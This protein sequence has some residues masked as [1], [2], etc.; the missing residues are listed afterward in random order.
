MKKKYVIIDAD[1]GIDDAMAI[2][3]ASYLKNIDILLA[4]GSTGN[5]LSKNSAVNNINILQSIGREN[6]KV[7]CGR[8]EALG[9]KTIVLNV[10]GLTGL[11]EFKFDK[12]KKEPIVG[13]IADTIHQTIKDVCEKITYICLGPATN[14]SYFIKKYPNDLNKFSA[15]YFSG[16]LIEEL[17]EDETP[18]LG[19]NA[20]FDPYAMEVLLSQDIPVYIVPSN[21]GHEAYLT[22]K[23]VSTIKHLNKTGAMFEEIFRFYHDRHVKNGIATHDLCGLMA[24]T[25]EKLFEFVNADVKVVYRKDLPSGVLSFNFMNGGRYYVAT[26]VNVKAVKRRFIKTIKRMP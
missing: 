2:S 6:I 19:F 26:G 4:I 23:D 12:P 17:S 11:G 8:E 18:Y 14:F 22:W 21:L 15:I 16:G 5:T 20:A 9:N 3:Y 7:A 13:D 1:T 25:D 10:H 24:F